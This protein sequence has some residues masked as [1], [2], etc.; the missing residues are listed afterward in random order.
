MFLHVTHAKPLDGYRL[1]VGFDDG[2][3]IH[4]F[5]IMAVIDGIVRIVRNKGCPFVCFL[6]FKYRTTERMEKIPDV[7][8]EFLSRFTHRHDWSLCPTFYAAVLPVIHLV[9]MIRHRGCLRM[10]LPD[11]SVIPV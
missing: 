3:S 10:M 9:D 11:D 6:Y 7:F 8:S 1:E 2:R 4:E 5:E